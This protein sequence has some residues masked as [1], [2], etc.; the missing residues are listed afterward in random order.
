M[1]THKIKSKPDISNG[2]K[3]HINVTVVQIQFLISTTHLSRT[4]SLLLQNIPLKTLPM[5][6]CLCG[7]FSLLSHHTPSTAQ[8][9]FVAQNRR[10]TI[11]PTHSEST[12]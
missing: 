9:H 11:S 4:H 6:L 1:E 3:Q 8:I 7:K 2:R 12:L 10:I 5:A